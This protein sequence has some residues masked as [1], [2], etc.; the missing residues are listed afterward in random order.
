MR[1]PFCAVCGETSNLEY[2]H[3]RPKSLGGSDD[4]KNILTL[5]GPCH[6]DFHGYSRVSNLGDLIF[7]GKFGLSR[8]EACE[9]WRSDIQL[10]LED[11]CK[12]TVELGTRLGLTPSGV[13]HRLINAGIRLL[14]QKPNPPAPSKYPK[15]VELSNVSR[16]QYDKK[17]RTFELWC[18][19]QGFDPL[20][21]PPAKIVEFM[22]TRGSR[23]RV[24]AAA[25][26]R[27]FRDHGLPKPTLSPEFKAFTKEKGPP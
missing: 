24:S 19:R 13:R 22:K 27:R 7:H 23:W 4:E 6:G 16:E 17:W 3:F 26:S 12:T 9:Q 2:H 25:I 5:C 1:I 10:A 21:A 18:F 11:G 8:E 15:V 14:S 20:E